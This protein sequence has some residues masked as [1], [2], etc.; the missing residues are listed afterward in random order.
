[1]PINH[2]IFI[3]LVLA[4]GFFLGWRSG[5]VAGAKDA[6]QRARSKLPD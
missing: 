1:M 2:V 3:P 5:F 4:L 6:V